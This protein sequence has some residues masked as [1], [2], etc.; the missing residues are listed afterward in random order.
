MVWQGGAE[1]LA[2]GITNELGEGV[3]ASV[4]RWPRDRKSVV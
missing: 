4:G 2:D 3:V 1:V